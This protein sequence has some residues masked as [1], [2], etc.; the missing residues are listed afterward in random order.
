MISQYRMVL[1][2]VSAT[3]AIST[4]PILARILSDVPAVG[5]S[6]WRMAIGATIL[7]VYSKF[8]PTV[9][10]ST[11]NRNYTI[12]GGIFLGIHF[13]FF[14]ESIKLTTIAN[15]TF[16]GTL[17]PLFTLLL[18]K[19]WLKRRIQKNMVFALAIIFTG[20]VIIVSDQFDAS[21]NYTRG[22]LYALICSFWIALAFMISENVRK[23][24]GTVTFSKTLFASAAITLL[25]ISFFT[26]E[27]LIGY[28]E[29]DYF[30]LFLLGLIP[31]VFGHGS[32]YFAL[33]YIQPTIVA[34][35]PLGE[36]I[37]A[38]IIAYYLFSE[39]VGINIVLGGVLTIVGLFILVKLRKV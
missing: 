23:E 5:I 6:F 3:F 34:S 21:S 25:M 39:A 27:S 1:L 7:W 20:S 19:F 29:L 30:G 4:S 37:I 33:R 14:F 15:A 28:S 12:L 35:F 10:L 22:N 18:E 32:F 2:L 26:G 16:L 8:K 38:S 13:Q 9:S 36:P 24:A 31:T 17:A 11:K